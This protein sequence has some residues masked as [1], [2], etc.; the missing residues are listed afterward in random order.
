MTVAGDA[1]DEANETVVVTLSSPTNAIVAT[2]TGTMAD[3]DA[4]GIAV[5][6][7]TSSTS[8]L[9]T[10]EAGGTA[11][12]TAVLESEPTG[13]RADLAAAIAC[14]RISP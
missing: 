9:R 12:F 11:T 5:S 2:A 1:L 13:N 8:R 14:R 3:D 7:T 4:A 10:T 6:P